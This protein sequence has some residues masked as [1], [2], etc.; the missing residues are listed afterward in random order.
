MQLGD[1]S[2]PPAMPEVSDDLPE[3]FWRSL[4][5]VLLE[6]SVVLLHLRVLPSSISQIHIEEGTM[7]CPNCNHLYVINNG[8]PNMV[9]VLVCNDHRK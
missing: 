8:I 5:H 1:T 3:E 6:V 7:V 4:H 9:S 2:L